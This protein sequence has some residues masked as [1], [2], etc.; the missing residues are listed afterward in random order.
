M[1][2]LR[3]EDDG[4]GG[5]IVPGNGLT[6][7]RERLGGV[8]AELRVDSGRGRGTVLMVSLPLPEQTAPAPVSQLQQAAQSS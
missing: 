8:G 6:G 5:A 7:M 2:V 3:V 1:L 4:R